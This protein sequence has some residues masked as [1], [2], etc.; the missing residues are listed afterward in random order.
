MNEPVS[1]TDELAVTAGSECSAG[2]GVVGTAL[3]NAT[4]EKRGAVIKGGDPDSWQPL[5]D[6]FQAD[7]SIWNFPCGQCLHREATADHCRGCR[8]WIA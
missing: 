4:R 2:L 6:L 5:P 1:K 7:E 3:V 8:H